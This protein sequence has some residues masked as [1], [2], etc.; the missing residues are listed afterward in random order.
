MTLM[1][2]KAVATQSWTGNF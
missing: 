2:D 1:K